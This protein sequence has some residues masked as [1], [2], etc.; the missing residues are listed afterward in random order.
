MIFYFNQ[1]PFS[2]KKKL[3]PVS[4]LKYLT[5]LIYTEEKKKKK[6]QIMNSYKL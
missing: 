3:Y 1:F 2:V 4:N 5:F 6:K